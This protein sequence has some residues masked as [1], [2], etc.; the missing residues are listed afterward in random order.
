MVSQSISQR[1]RATS[2]PTAASPAPTSPVRSAP[3]PAN[4]AAD[5]V[6]PS[7]VADPAPAAATAGGRPSTS[8]SA[9][10]SPAAAAALLSSSSSGAPRVQP[11]NTFDSRSPSIHS[12]PS[13]PMAPECCSRFAVGYSSSRDVKLAVAQAFSM[14]VTKLSNCTP[15]VVLVIQSSRYPTDEIS[16]CLR[17][18]AAPRD[19]CAAARRAVVP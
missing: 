15:S 7:A 5:A 2:Q 1:A 11:S 16:R 13:M 14:L 4:A 17:V 3:G 19:R 6:W 9:S 18:R 8:A 12:A 10:A